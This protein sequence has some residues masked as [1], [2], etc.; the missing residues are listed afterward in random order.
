[1]N[2]G[3]IFELK[4]ESEGLSTDLTHSVGL[5]FHSMNTCKMIPQ[6]ILL[7]ESLF[8]YI[9]FKSSLAFVSQHV[10]VQGALL[11]KSFPACLTRVRPF[12]AMHPKMQR[13]TRRVN[14]VLIAEIASRPRTNLRRAFRQRGFHFGLCFHRLCDNF[15]F[16]ER[17]G[18]VTFDMLFEH[19]VLSR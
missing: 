19:F 4:R 10:L 13:E 18:A 11:G 7:N 5:L 3:V 8:T 15:D 16:L 1:M 14:K 6:V 2:F 17:F 12:T 9:A